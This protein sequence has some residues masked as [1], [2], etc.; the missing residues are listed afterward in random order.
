MSNV[1]CYPE[2]LD[3]LGIV[4]GIGHEIDLI[5]HIDRLAGPYEGVIWWYNE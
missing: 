1:N 5:G 2:R 4:G 3:P